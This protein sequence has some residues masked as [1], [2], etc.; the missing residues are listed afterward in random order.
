MVHLFLPVNCAKQILRCF[1]IK[2]RPESSLEQFRSVCLRPDL[3]R[4]LLHQCQ[5]GPLFLF[6]QLIAD[7]TRGKSA[8]RAQIQP[9]DIHDLR[10]L[11]DPVDDRLLILQLR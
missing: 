8:L 11:M 2:K 1:S 6:R 10:C 9:V 4:D 7:L 3:F 5:F